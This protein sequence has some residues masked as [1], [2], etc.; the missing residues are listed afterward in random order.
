MSKT[1]NN[2][3]VCFGYT[4]LASHGFY[5]PFFDY[6]IK[7]FSK[8]YEELLFIQKK[9]M[10]SN[11]YVYYSENGFNALSLD[12]LPFNILKDIYKNCKIICDDYIELGLKRDFLTLRL[13]K[14]KKLC[15]TLKTDTIYYRKSLSHAL[16]LIE[17][18]D[19]PV[20]ID[21]TFD[22]NTVLRLKAY[23]SQKHG[24]LEVKNLE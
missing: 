22:S 21:N 18:L 19:T 3:K 17:F 14:D 4:N 5:L 7:D 11:I 1:T 10:L 9:F 2:S 13:G 20:N 16:L 24:F 8:V 12:K 6:D 23:R 15:H